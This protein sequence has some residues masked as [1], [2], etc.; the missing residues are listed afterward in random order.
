MV[1]GQGSMM[2]LENRLFSE[3]T[4]RGFFGGVAGDPDRRYKGTTPGRYLGDLLG[5]PTNL[6]N[7]IHHETLN[8]GMHNLNFGAG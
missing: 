1:P 5:T 2:A 6:Q 8:T 3:A 7:L 4:R